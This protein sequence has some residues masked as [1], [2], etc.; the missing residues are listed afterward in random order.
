MISLAS[1]THTPLLGLGLEGDVI[2]GQ[3]TVRH[4]LQLE[5]VLT[6]VTDIHQHQ[7]A[8][9]KITPCIVH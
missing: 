9:C 2:L 1:F 3:R 8:L 6:A 7:L 5:H 4:T